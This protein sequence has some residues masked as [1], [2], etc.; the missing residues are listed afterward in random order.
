MKE[1]HLRKWHRTGGI[2]FAFFIVVQALTGLIITLKDIL[3]ASGD[4]VFNTI[5]TQIEGAGEV[6]RVLAGVGMLFMACTG[7]WIWF[8]IRRR[9]HTSG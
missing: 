2:L 7:V 5:H 4:D 9:T 3:G 6:N 1:A 8:M